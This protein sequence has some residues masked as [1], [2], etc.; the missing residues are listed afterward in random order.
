[1][2]HWPLANKNH[3]LAFQPWLALWAWKKISKEHR[4]CSLCNWLYISAAFSLF[5]GWEIPGWHMEETVAFHRLRLAGEEVKIKPGGHGKEITTLTPLANKWSS[6]LALFLSVILLS[7][8]FLSLYWNRLTHRYRSV[9]A[10]VACITTHFR[11]RD[12]KEITPMYL[13]KIGQ[14]F[15]LWNWLWQYFRQNSSSHWLPLKWLDFAHE[16][17]PSNGNV[18]EGNINI[19]SK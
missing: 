9:I 3:V 15:K 13:S 10:Q 1:M 14:F 19:L 11:C 5:K 16:M 7:L 18:T 6:W 4:K 12:G 2:V 8:S 17:L